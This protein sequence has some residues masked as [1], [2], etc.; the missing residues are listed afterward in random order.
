MAEHPARGID[1]VGITVPDVE[2]ATR[3]FVAAFGAEVLYD[4]IV[5]DDQGKPVLQPPGASPVEY[6]RVTAVGLPK[7]ATPVRV[8][9]M[10]LANGPSLELFEFRGVVPAPPGTATDLGLQ[11]IAIYVD[12]IEAVAA[13]VEMAGGTL[14]AGPNRAPGWESGKHSCFQYTRAPWG[15][16]IE[17]IAYPHGQINESLGRTRWSPAR[18]GDV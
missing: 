7:D 14:L 5:P 16:A 15:T 6:D 9:L 2:A 11:H 8:R 12:D 17:L 3:F 18:T 1:H 13:G 10:R 4:L